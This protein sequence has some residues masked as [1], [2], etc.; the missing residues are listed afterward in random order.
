ML[1]TEPRGRER[2]EP[3]VADRLVADLARAVGA[4]GDPLLGVIDVFQAGLQRLADRQI[5]FAL[6]RLSSDV[7]LVFVHHR[8]FLQRLLLRLEVGLETL[9]GGGQP[10]ALVLKALPGGSG[11]HQAGSSSRGR[12]CAARLSSSGDRSGRDFPAASGT[13]SSKLASS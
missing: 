4:V 12:G 11:V 2:L 8:Q 7:A 1:D 5:L 9:K 10:L 13:S 3:L 6:E